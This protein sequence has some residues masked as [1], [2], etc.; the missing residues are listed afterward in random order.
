MDMDGLFRHLKSNFIQWAALFVLVASMIAASRAAFV[1]MLLSWGR[2]ILPFFIVWLIYRV[3]RKR[4]ETALKRFQ[5][6]VMQNIQNG[7]DGY[8]GNSPGGRG[9][10][11]VLDLCPKCG[12]LLSPAHRCP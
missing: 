10:Q 1:P 4:I 12:A 11:Q 9:R 3:V 2:L 7:P 5:D 8:A 6:Q